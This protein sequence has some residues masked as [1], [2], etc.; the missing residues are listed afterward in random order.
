[1]QGQLSI[2]IGQIN[3]TVGD[4]DGN[5]ALMADI[6]RQA[7]GEGADM[8]VFPELALT[9]YTPGDL[10]DDPL[11]EHR[12]AIAQTQLYEATRQTPDVHWVVGLPIVREATAGRAFYNA[13]QVLLDG[14]VVL[15][16]IKQCV[17]ADGVFDERRHFAPGPTSARI[18]RI[19]GAAVGF[20]VGED[21]WQDDGDEDD[22]PWRRLADAAPDLVI[23]IQAG[24]STKGAR[25]LRHDR[26]SR[27]CACHGV[28]MLSIAQVG[29]QDHVVFDGASFA[30]DVSGNVVFEGQRFAVDR[31]L[32]RF[33]IV[34]HQFVDAKSRVLEPLPKDGLPLMEFYRRQIIL[35]LRD[36]ARRCG[37]DKVLVGSSGG[38]D[39]ALTIALAAQAMGPENVVAITMPSDYSSEGSVSD[40]VTLCRNL[41]VQLLEIPIRDIVSQFSGAMQ[42]SALGEGPDGVALE[43]LQARVRGTILMTYSNQYGPLL[44]MTG[45]K[46]E[47][48]VGY[49]TLYGDT[50]G[51]LGLIGDLYKTEV[52]ALSR[53]MNAS[54]GRELIP[55]V[56]INKAPSAELSPG[57][58]D[59][60]SLPPYEVLDEVLKLRIEGPLLDANELASA[61]QTVTDLQG[62]EHGRS[63][64]DKVERLIAASEFKRRQLAP[65]IRVRA[66]PHGSGRQAFI[67]ARRR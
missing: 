24:P 62:S 63:I 67:V 2:K 37:F 6:A 44:L 11:F 41:G 55:D 38:I 33:D 21:A 51:G 22:Q 59:S 17:A 52:F 43:N 35:G 60:D 25:E 54:A 29:G 46:S 58:K 15:T 31:S 45:N 47:A 13:L 53:Y 5:I 1:M 49:C 42:H 48:F 39:S 50:N 8:V 27:L 14:R 4:M 20:L 26:A 12:L 18:L 30:M 7:Q 36:Y 10:L 57:Q 28:S 66:V 3:P 65:I 40:S 19:R 32:V 34:A 16:Q 23:A 9:G 64:L 61:Q 56:I